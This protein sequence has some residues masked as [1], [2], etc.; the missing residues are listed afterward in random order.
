MNSISLGRL[1]LRRD[2]ST[3]KAWTFRAASKR[4]FSL[5]A[6]VFEFQPEY[7]LG[8][9]LF[10]SFRRVASVALGELEAGALSPLLARP[11]LLRP[12]EVARRTRAV[13]K[14][15]GSDKG[16]FGLL[17]PDGAVRVSTLSF[18][19]LPSDPREQESLI[20]WKMRPLLPFAVEEARLSYELSPKDPEGVEAV[21]MSV[22]KSVLAEYESTLEELNGDVSLVLPSSAAL[23]PLLK[24][25]AE[26]GEMLLNISPTHLTAV[27]AKS[28]QIKLWRN[29]AMG[30]KSSEEGLAA[31]TEEAVRTL[32]ASH[33]HLGLEISRVCIAARPNVPRPWVLELGEKLSRSVA[34]VLPADLAVK[35]R[36]SYEEGQILNEFGAT[37]SGLVANAA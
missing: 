24:E 9:R 34:D 15:L 17:L 33:D 4:K 20:R 25:D 23:L 11:N 13:A 10:R 3:A 31:V 1:K 22:R 6:T 12:D 19:T 14:A 16:P 2:S 37:I 29:Q 36:L 32:A 30:G 8:A 7:I 26:A 21:V 5:P 35:M 27:V 28:R 18:E